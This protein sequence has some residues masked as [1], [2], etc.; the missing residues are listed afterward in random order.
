[1]N[2]AFLNSFCCS[3]GKVGGRGWDLNETS[4]V[5]HIASMDRPSLFGNKIRGCGHAIAPMHK[6]LPI[7]NSFE[8]IKISP[9]NLVFELII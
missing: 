7:K 8:S 4:V 1:M 6:W 9:T 2:P 3:S 5:N